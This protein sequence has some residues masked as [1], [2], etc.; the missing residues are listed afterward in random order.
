[1]MVVLFY[2]GITSKNKGGLMHKPKKNNIVAKWLLIIYLIIIGLIMCFAGFG[3]ARASA[4]SG[5]VMQPPLCATV[6]TFRSWFCGLTRYKADATGNE[7]LNS[8]GRK[9]VELKDII[10]IVRTDKNTGVRYVK[11]KQTNTEREFNETREVTLMVFI[12]TI[13]MNVLTDVFM[14]AGFVA[15]GFIIYGG[16]LY[17]ISHGSSEQIVKAK[18]TITNAIIGLVI[19]ILATAIV[20]TLTSVL[21]G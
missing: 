9:T 17:I 10:E 19:A 12:W 2:V 1:M 11:D 13:V 7:V 5:A 14:L 15:V 3:G 8:G 6:L 18:K 4:A 20:S 21:T 16:Y